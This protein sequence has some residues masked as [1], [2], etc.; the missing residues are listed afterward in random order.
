[1]VA[2]GITKCSADA[3]MTADLT[4]LSQRPTREIHYSIQIS[5]DNFRHPFDICSGVLQPETSSST[6]ASNRWLRFAMLPAAIK[7][8]S[9]DPTTE[10]S[11]PA[12]M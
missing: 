12:S 10:M 2:A 7:A 4:K 8:S 9:T 5:A 1:M 6:Q 11:K 3:R